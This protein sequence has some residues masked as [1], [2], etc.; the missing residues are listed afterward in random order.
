MSLVVVLKYLR[1]SDNMR[2]DNDFGHFIISKGDVY[3]IKELA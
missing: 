2:W 3:I 1:T